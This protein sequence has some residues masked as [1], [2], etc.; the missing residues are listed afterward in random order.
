[1]IGIYK[2]EN[3][4]TGDIY[5]GSSRTIEKRKK[6]HF[7]SLLKNTHHSIV[8]QRAYNKYGK[9]AF[10]FTILEECLVVELF[11]KEQ[12]YID[13]LS[14]KYNIRLIACGLS[15]TKQNEDSRRLR[16]EYAIR[17][18]IKPPEGTW[19]DKMKKVI[20]LDYSSLNVLREFESSSDACRYI[21]KDHTFCST[22]TS[23]C[24]NKRFSAFGYRWVFSEDDIS[25]LRDKI[26]LV[27]WNK[28]KKIDNKRSKKITQFSLDGTFIR[29]WNSIQEAELVV[30]HGIS[31]C[32]SGKS[33]TSNGFIWK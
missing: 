2:I 22:I 18:G 11:D 13:N 14:P 23:C 19:R 7:N 10:V 24:S 32:I 21:G 17:N 33:K 25:S 31:N 27:A 9:D 28:G 8:L 4:I 15:G 12:H 29:E 20:M 5:I 30:G 1:M 26:Q 16:S 3:C 6:R